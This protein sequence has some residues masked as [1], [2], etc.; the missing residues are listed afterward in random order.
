MK[1]KSNER[2]RSVRGLNSN[3]PRRN[4]GDKVLHFEKHTPPRE[5]DPRDPTLKSDLHALEC[6]PDHLRLG[7]KF[8]F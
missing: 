3:A 1:G 2:A 4:L 7:I 8:W 5:G 6:P